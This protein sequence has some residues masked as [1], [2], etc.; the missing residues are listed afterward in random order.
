MII[1]IDS[2]RRGNLVLRNENDIFE[3][4]INQSHKNKIIFCQTPKNT[5]IDIT[6]PVTQHEVQQKKPPFELIILRYDYLEDKVSILITRFL[7]MY[8]LMHME[9]NNVQPLFSR[10]L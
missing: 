6:I 8:R 5:T 3:K 2:L 1:I 10:T 7:C 9:K 4:K